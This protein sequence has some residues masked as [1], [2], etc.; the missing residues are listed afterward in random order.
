MW[1]LWAHNRSLK[2]NTTGIWNAFC[3]VRYLDMCN[4]RALA[5]VPL[6]GLQKRLKIL[7]TLIKDN[8]R[9]HCPHMFFFASALALNIQ[10]FILSSLTV[11]CGSFVTATVSRKTQ[12]DSVWMKR[13]GQPSTAQAPITEFSHQIAMS[14]FFR[15]CWYLTERVDRLLTDVGD[16]RNMTAMRFQLTVS[17]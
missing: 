12:A 8:L 5:V 2:N 11:A 4:K 14:V 13:Y 10:P 1:K 6:A 9:R 17:S 16:R 7:H 15:R 3:F